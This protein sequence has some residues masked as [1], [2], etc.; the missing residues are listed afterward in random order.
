MRSDSVA[1]PRLPAQ[2]H[3]RVAQFVVRVGESWRVFDGLALECHRAGVIAH[4]RGR[5]A[6]VAQ[7]FAVVR[8]QCE[9]LVHQRDGANQFVAPHGEHA[10]IVQRAGTAGI[11]RE[12]SFVER[13]RGGKLARAMFGKTGGYQLNGFGGGGKRGRSKVVVH[14][15]RG[16]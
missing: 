12:G 5:H 13:L 4:A 11:A 10:Q 16:A 9:R 7:A 8:R 15:D 14:A 6:A 1:R 3:Q 2:F